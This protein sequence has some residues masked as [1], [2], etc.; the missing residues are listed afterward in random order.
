MRWIDEDAP[1]RSPIAHGLKRLLA[2]AVALGLACGANAE[3]TLAPAAAQAMFAR[4]KDKL[5]QVRTIHALSQSQASIG[6]GF[7][8]S[9]DG[10]VITNYHVVRNMCWI[11]TA[12]GW[13]RYAMT[14]RTASSRSPPSMWRTIWRC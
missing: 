4:T 5:I 3:S 7:I 12:I 8:A 6:S 9:P 1:L 13:S 14:A 11:R 10:L 2:A